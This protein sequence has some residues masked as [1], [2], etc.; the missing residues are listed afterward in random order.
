MRISPARIWRERGAR[1]R[2]EGIRCRDCNAVMYPPKAACPLCGSRNIER[3]ELSKR[4]KLITW[5]VEY[6]VPEGYRACAPLIVGLIELESGA[7]ILAPL[8]DVEPDELRPGM[9]VEAVLRKVVEDGD[10]GLIVYAI[11]FVPTR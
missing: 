8:T 10:T 1:Y 2:I 7:R 6:V 9:E 3:I 5:T 4:G 11:K